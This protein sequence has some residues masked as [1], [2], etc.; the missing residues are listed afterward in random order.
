MT[1]CR[2][3]QLTVACRGKTS[4]NLEDVTKHI[5]GGKNGWIR[6]LWVGRNIWREKKGKSCW[7]DPYCRYYCMHFPLISFHPVCTEKVTGWGHWSCLCLCEC[8]VFLSV[9]SCMVGCTLLRM[10]ELRQPQLYCAVGLVTANKHD[11]IWKE[12]FSFCFCTVFFWVLTILLLS[13]LLQLKFFAED[14]RLVGI[15]LCMGHS[16][17]ILG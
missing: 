6:V 3:A 15:A 14:W 17:L 9:L 7:R 4:W 11:W 10:M 16:N 1:V 13:Y 12:N 2:N 5:L 8:W